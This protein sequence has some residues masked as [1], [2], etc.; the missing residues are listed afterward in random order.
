M[1]SLLA[2]I[3][4]LEREKIRERSVTGLAPPP[5]SSCASGDAAESGVR[6]H[7]DVLTEWELLQRGSD[8]INLLHGAQSWRIARVIINWA[9][10]FRQLRPLPQNPA[11]SISLID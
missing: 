9:P 4:K 11:P 1:V 8:L 5:A 10:L 7:C 3:A 6:D 2:S